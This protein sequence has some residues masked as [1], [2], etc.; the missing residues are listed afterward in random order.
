M[1]YP[2]LQSARASLAWESK[3]SLQASCDIFSW[4]LARRE[5]PGPPTFWIRACSNLSPLQA[6]YSLMSASTIFFPKTLR[7]LA[8]NSDEDSSLSSDQIL[9]AKAGAA[10]TTKLHKPSENSLLS[11][12][13][14]PRTRP[15]FFF[16]TL[17][18]Y[19]HNPS[20]VTPSF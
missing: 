7:F 11:I 15:Q 6:V 20:L 5:G 10:L 3:Y 12:A 16:L 2:G 8:L 4:A 1:A 9:F 14:N 19:S 13:T 17:T 18:L